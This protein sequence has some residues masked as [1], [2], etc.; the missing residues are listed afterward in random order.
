MSDGVSKTILIL[1]VKPGAA[2]LSALNGRRTNGEGRKTVLGA[3]EGSEGG[4]SKGVREEHDV[5][6]L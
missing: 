3:G 4:T 2:Y 5:K 6:S 1:W